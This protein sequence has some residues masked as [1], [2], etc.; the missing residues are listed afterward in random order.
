[1]IL[2]L[3]T[4]WGRRDKQLFALYLKAARQPVL[5][6]LNKVEESNL[7]APSLNDIKQGLP[8]TQNGPGIPGPSSKNPKLLNQ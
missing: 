4:L 3:H 7:D 8:R 2:T 1:M 5:V 6:A